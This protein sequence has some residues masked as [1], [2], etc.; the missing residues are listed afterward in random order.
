M[1]RWRAAVWLLGAA[2]PIACGGE[3]PAA[4][5]AATEDVTL[6]SLSPALVL[7]GSRVVLGGASFLPS[8][9]GP[10]RLRLRGTLGGAGVDVV[11]PAEFVDYDRLEVR[12]PGGEAAGLPSEEGRFEGVA[13]VEAHSS[14]DG[15]DHR[16]RALPVTLEVRR[17]LAP[18]LDAVESAASFVNDPVGLAGDGFL[19]G[20]G[21]GESL[22]VVEGCF[23]E[24]GAT[25]CQA[26][27]PVEIP[28]APLVAFERRRIW[29]PFAPTIA[30]IRPGH[31]EGTVRIVNRH[32]SGE[33]PSTG[34][35]ATAHDVYEPV[36]A[37]ISPGTASLGQY[38][39]VA[40]AGFVGARPGEPN[41][42]LA[43]TLVDLDGTFTPEGGAPRP[44]KVSLVP[45]FVSGQLVRY[46]LAEED[47]LGQSVDL[48]TVAGTF[49]GTARPVVR[50]GDDEV[51]GAAVDV[52]L[53]IGHVRQVVWLRFL[54]HY[55]ES[56]RH[57]GL[58]A[59]DARVRARVL[60]VVRR[61][62]AGV[63]VDVRTTAPT[64]FALFAEV[65]IG[66]PDPNGIGLLGYDNTPG[67]DDGNLRLY[68]KIGGVNALTQLDGFPG[69]GGVFVE[70]L[71]GFSTHPNGLAEANEGADVA[72]DQ[73]FDPFRQDLG[74][75]AVTAEELG[76]V[77]DLE[78]GEGCPA[79]KRAGQIA[80]AVWALG[81]LIGTTVSHELAH[82]LGLADPGGPSFHN[83]QDWPDAIMDAGGAR[84]FRERA[85][86]SGE[87]PGAFCQV[88]YAY[89]RQ[90][91]PTSDPDPLPVR[92]QCH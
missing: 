17:L 34:P 76:G 85:E 69:Y 70:S 90:I 35:L 12:W 47:A 55:K 2:A 27:G 89:L 22:A 49:A 39:D 18:R 26:V 5:A 25:G 77:P 68:D 6:A 83:S 43:V 91:L 31:F 84:P 60:D 86:V 8:F 20:E 41:P 67:K 56:L 15:L 75:A 79:K 50:W 29:F 24:E 48:R 9:A 16:S 7:P 80:C 28:A 57:F 30:G 40:G 36:L 10:S 78:G 87:G 45:E 59:A 32:A 72:F 52:T 71:F 11:L 23:T 88:D 3:E 33:E 62:Y 13:A 14:L 61:D 19:L 63:G 81:S 66:G 51:A 73:L 37:G 42:T 38:V 64:D 58:R 65:E 74:A 1:R 92:Q 4:G 82:S 54:P 53:G 21:E 44:A 46:V